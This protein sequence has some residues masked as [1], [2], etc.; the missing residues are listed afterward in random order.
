MYRI[1]KS[2]PIRRPRR[3]A[4]PSIE[5]LLLAGADVVTGGRL[6]RSEAVLVDRGKVAAV[7]RAALTRAR[8][9]RVRRVDVEGLYLAPGF[10]DLHTH[11][12]VGVDFVKAGEKDFS[13]AMAHYLAK[14]VTGLLVSV[15]PMPMPEMLEALR[16]IAGFI[17]DGAGPA[18]GIHLEGPY[19]SPRRP[20]AL[21]LEHFKVYRRSEVDDLLQAGGGFVRTMT[22]A[23]EL[24][25]GHDLIRHLLGR[26]VVPSFGHSDADHEGTRKAIEAGV[27]HATHLF[28]A[29]RGIHHRDPGPVTALL[30][31]ERVLVEL[32][33]DGFHVAP[34]VLKLVHGAKPRRQVILVSDSVAPCGLAEG[35]Y[36]FA[37]K[38]VHLRGGRVT[39]PDGTLAGSALAMDRAVALTVKDVGLPLE[40]AVLLATGNPARLLGEERA[41][42]AVAPGRRADL[43][44]LGRNLRVRATW[45]EGKQVHGAKL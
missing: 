8:R 7:G 32:I 6:R 35:A 25:G 17:R 43:V 28:N 9:D 41:R 19:V 13:R 18:F 45:L 42:G 27:R 37:G 22:L 10:L 12:A 33:S 30:G 1:A 38:P 20:G 23:P 21:P 5:A 36:D 26:G 3:G 11:G 34:P 14:G 44:L 31:D 29:M 16:R 40:E 24:P 4:H 15:Y 2:L 39:L